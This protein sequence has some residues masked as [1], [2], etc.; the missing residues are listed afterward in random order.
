MKKFSQL[1]PAALL[2]VSLL[3]VVFSISS[4]TPISSIRTNT[5]LRAQDKRERDHV[6]LGSEVR[7]RVE[8]L[9]KHNKNVRADISDLEKN[10][11]R[12]RHRQKYDASF[13]VSLDPVGVPASNATLK[14]ALSASRFRKVSFKA[15]DPDYSACGVELIFIPTYDTSNE[16]QG[17]VILN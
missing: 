4:A 13:S 7:R 8:L 17:T 11:T 6:K 16:W 14:N 2:G 1:V 9:E 10:E 3:A 15:Q 12:N 5:G